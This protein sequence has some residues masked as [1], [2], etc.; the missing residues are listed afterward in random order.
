MS[1]NKDSYD[2]LFWVHA[3]NKYK[4]QAKIRGKITFLT[5]DVDYKI[6]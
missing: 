1:D 4:I 2:I 5:V 3:E 6:D